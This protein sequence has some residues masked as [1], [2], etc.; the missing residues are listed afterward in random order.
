MAYALLRDPLPAN[1]ETAI[2]EPREALIFN[3]NPQIDGHSATT[4][5]L[6]LRDPH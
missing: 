1:S 4:Y 2:F 6:T 5:Q 3:R